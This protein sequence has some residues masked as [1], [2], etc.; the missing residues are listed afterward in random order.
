MSSI[1]TNSLNTN[2]PVPGINNDT[3]GFRTNF[4]NIKNNLDSAANEITDLQNKVVL[5][6]ALSG[7][8]VN[9]DMA[10]TLISNALTKSFRA[11]TYNLGNNINT[12][13]EAN[14][15]VTVNV[16]AGDVQYG[17]ITGNTTLKFGAWAPAGTQSNV[18]LVLNVSNANAVITLPVTTIDANGYASQGMTVSVRNLENYISNLSGAPT[19]NASFTNQLT[20]PNGVSQLHYRFSTLDCGTTVHIEPVNRSQ[21]ASQINLRT[22]TA[23]GSVGDR[24]GTVCYDNNFFYVC[25]GNFDGSTNIW[26]KVALL[27][28]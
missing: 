11:S 4:N 9:N 18:E 6:S 3:S 10:N 16:S 7:T 26:K 24:S 19:A 22:P 12:I 27:P 23:T 1:N 15:S 8:T 2:F 25:T 28:V 20:T 21:K 5:K 13:S 14:S 17:T